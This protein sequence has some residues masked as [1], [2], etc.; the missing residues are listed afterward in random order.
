MP[1]TKSPL[2][3]GFTLIEMS[4]VLVIIGLIVGGI[5]TGRDLIDAAAQR[6]Q[7]AQINKYNV[8]VRTFQ[9][10]YG[11]LPGDIPD[12]TASMFG[13]QP[14]GQYAGEGDGNGILEGVWQNAP[15]SNNGYYGQTGEE[16]M[17]WVD[18]STAGLIDGGFNTATSATVGADVSGSG[19]SAYMPTAKIANG[20][21][22]YVW[23]G[24]MNDSGV[25]PPTAYNGI[26]YYGLAVVTSFTVGIIKSTKMS[27]SVNQAYN[28]DKKID[29][30]YPLTGF[31]TATYQS[32]GNWWVGQIPE[33]STWST[34][35]TPTT[36]YDNGGTNG[37]TQQYSMGSNG[38]NGMNCAL[39]FRFQ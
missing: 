2:K 17:F 23:S 13:F 25:G 4:I 1:S 29:D 9:G 18:L 33:H 16:A 5:L 19:L 36:C 6:A 14:R 35:Q 32:S 22:V 27:L 38:G 39:S 30:G 10:K 3:S 24:G 15:N 8:A 20:N 7:I 31:V 26:N 34:A 11:S 37:A 12:P 21:Y 28:I